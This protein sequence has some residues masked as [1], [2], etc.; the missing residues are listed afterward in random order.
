M[1]PDIIYIKQSL[2]SELPGKQAQFQ[3][4]P[5]M[6]LH[7]PETKDAQ[8]AAVLI[9]LYPHNNELHTV[10]MKRPEETGHHSGQV[11]FPGGKNELH[12]INLEQTALREASEEIGVIPNDIEIIGKLTPLNIP[13]SNFEVHP[14]VGYI[15]Y[16]PNF[17]PDPVEVAYLIEPSL[18]LLLA[19]KTRCEESRIFRNTK[20]NVPYF[21]V[22]NEKIWG[23][24]AM[25]LNE[26]LTV[27]NK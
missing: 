18:S 24:T 15:N 4:A 23:A 2:L 16:K 8:P 25:M 20:V 1:K 9:L 27:I 17:I 19:N 12:D 14:Y 7:F 22:N 13:V 5:E 26:F 21:N 10:F 11:S 6:R 3:M